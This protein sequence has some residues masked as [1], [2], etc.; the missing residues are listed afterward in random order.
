[1]SWI[2][3]LADTYDSILKQGELELLPI[4]HST[5]NTH[6]EVTINSNSELIHAELVDKE[7]SE[8]LIP[9][10]EGSASRGSG[11]FPHPLCDKL[12]YLA[13]DYYEYVDKKKNTF[14]EDYMHQLKNWKNSS[15]TNAKVE[16]IY[17]YLKKGK[18]ITD[19]IKYGTLVIDE[20]NKLDTK[21]LKTDKKIAVGSQSDSFIRFRV[22]T[23]D[24]LVDAVWQDKGMIADYINYYLSNQGNKKICYVSGKETSCTNKHPSKITHTGDKSK[25]ISAN[26]T[27]NFTFRG[28]FHNA[29]EAVTVG[30][31][32]SQKAHNALKYV[33]KK[34]GQRIGDKTF[35]LWGTDNQDVPNY[36]DDTVDF[37]VD[38]LGL[39]ENSDITKKDLAIKFNKAILGFKSK[40]K[41]NTKM[42]LMGLEPPTTGRLAIIFYREYN[43][44]EGHE[45]ID[46]IEKWHKEAS[47][48]HRYKFI[49]KL[50]Y[51]FKGAPS[52]FDIGK[53]TYG[54]EQNGKINADDKLTANAIV[55]IVP[56][57]IE[58]KKIPKDIVFKL[59]N[60]AKQ[61][62]NYNKRHNWHKVVTIT[63]AIYR[64]Y[65]IDYEKEEYSVEIRETDN[66]AYNCG[67]LLAVADAI[68]SWSLRDNSKPKSEIRA[69]NAI[70]Y[71]TKFSISPAS[72]WKIINDKLITHKQRLGRRGAKL[73]KLLGE[74]SSKI[75][76]DEFSKAKNLDG[77]VVL[78]Y[79]SQ[80]QALFNMSKENI[81]EE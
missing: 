59:V 12:Q 32:V 52:V 76:P 74:I 1:M 80:R 64:K 65:L 39:N 50:N 79:D 13:G 6:I 34:Q 2:S 37:A 21:F 38:I 30:Y 43:G 14:H 73:Y 36:F 78:G 63:C 68:E 25:L 46:N 31:E 22:V 10:T 3:T 23:F 70:R 55:R 7:D 77:C 57:I 26:D 69:T 19:L 81:E 9:V 41:P 61:P 28:R 71:F 18:L 17:D 20:N 42:A 44:L 4:A 53:V 24:S 45:L 29:D 33:I 60:K 47:W 48:T 5:Q 35:V 49:N 54:N 75:D 66:L 58:G 67:R 8:T 56:S 16:I 11:S 40:I 62:Q 27:S 51:Q 15:H 72:T